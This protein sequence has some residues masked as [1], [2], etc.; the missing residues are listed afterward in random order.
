MNNEKGAIHILF[1]LMVASIVILGGLWLKK[2]KDPDTDKNIVNSE[3]VNTVEITTKGMKRFTNNK[4]GFSFQFPTNIDGFTITLK[5]IK[6]AMYPNRNEDSVSLY[7]ENYDAGV[8]ITVFDTEAN[9]ASEWWN[10]T[11]ENENFTSISNRK[12][13]DYTLK[14]V[15]IGLYDLLSFQSNR[16]AHG[17]HILTRNGK[18][19]VFDYLPMNTGVDYK[20]MLENILNTFAFNQEN[21][22]NCE[23]GFSEYEDAFISVCYPNS[24]ISSD[25]NYSDESDIYSLLFVNNNEHTQLF[26]QNRAAVGFDNDDC[27]KKEPTT[28]SGYESKRY[29]ISSGPNCDE[30][31]QFSTFTNLKDDLLWGLTYSG[32]V[33]LKDYNQIE[34]SFKF[35]KGNTTN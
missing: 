32:T 26:I 3:T 33:T 10:E 6:P 15:K 12:K 23:T 18:S 29:T 25:Y 9:S 27:I 17:G 31:Y 21:S 7:I 34:S 30:I 4:H 5:E 35:K 1:L 28:M 22:A 19:Y 13:S 11:F 14:D 20:E 8:M 16:V 2:Q 24:L